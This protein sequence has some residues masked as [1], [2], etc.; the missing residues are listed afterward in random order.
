M[1][2][3]PEVTVYDTAAIMR[4][5]PHRFPF[6]MIDRVVDVGEKHA[7]AVK[8]VSINEPFFAGHFPEYPIMPGVLLAECMAQTSAFIGR[9]PD[10]VQT[11]DSAGEA[12]Y[13]VAGMNLKISKSVVP[14]DRLVIRMSVVT[15]FGDLR[16]CRG[17]I[18]V[19]RRAVATGE[20]S[21]VRKG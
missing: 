21:L 19:D 2:A 16:K 20:F 4:V 6:L 8:Y 7:V 14:G 10:A 13:L 9:R 11:G 12:R 18:L 15:T 5:L 17:E 1:T 3:D